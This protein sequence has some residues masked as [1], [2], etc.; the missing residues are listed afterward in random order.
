MKWVRRCVCVNNKEI[1]FWVSA[2]KSGNTQ[3]VVRCFEKYETLW[4][5]KY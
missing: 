1:K 3:R 4:R 5:S 2:T